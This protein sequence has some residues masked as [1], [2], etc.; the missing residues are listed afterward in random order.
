MELNDLEPL[1][2]QQ[3]LI[4]RKELPQ[5]LSYNLSIKCRNC[6]YNNQQK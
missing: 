4:S 6:A 5:L 1:L 2:S 3:H